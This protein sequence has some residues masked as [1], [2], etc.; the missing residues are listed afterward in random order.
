MANWCKPFPQIHWDPWHILLMGKD[1][2]VAARTKQWFFPRRMGRR[3]RDSR[4]GGLSLAYSSDGKYLASRAGQRLRVWN[5]ST[6]LPVVAESGEFGGSRDPVLTM[7]RRMND[8]WPLPIGSAVVQSDSGTLKDLHAIHNFLVPENR[9]KRL[10]VCHLSFSADQKEL[11]AGLYEGGVEIWNLDSGTR[12]KPVEFRE[13]FG[14][15]YYVTSFPRTGKRVSS[16]AT[17]GGRP[18]FGTRPDA[19]GLR[20]GPSRRAAGSFPKPGGSSRVAGRRHSF[21]RL[22]DPIGFI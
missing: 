18:P 20:N 3:C 10:S 19:L 22:R 12:Q 7:P 13:A 6:G 21:P 9:S 8:F 2:P 17:I 4:S 5:S 16:M 11:R 1:W 15:P 14:P